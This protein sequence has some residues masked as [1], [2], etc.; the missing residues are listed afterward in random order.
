M[1]IQINLA[2][3]GIFILFILLTVLITYVI[4][5][6]KNLNETMKVIKTT[7]SKNQKNIDEILNQA[8]SITAN[9][10]SISSDLSTNVKAVQSTIGHIITT[11]EMATAS[12][13]N[14]QEYFSNILGF[15]QIISK[16]K[17]FINKPFLHKKKRVK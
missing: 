4:F 15:V 2:D 17:E 8:P 1:N 3:L 13:S 9:I 14:T 5:I 12:L 10:D 11:T 6:L 16:I 7:V